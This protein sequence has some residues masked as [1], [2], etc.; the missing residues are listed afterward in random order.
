MRLLHEAFN[1][2]V[3]FRSFIDEF[4]RFDEFDI[5]MISKEYERKFD[6]RINIKNVDEK[7]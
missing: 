6:A 1:E 7:N 2:E 4:D 3:I 5:D